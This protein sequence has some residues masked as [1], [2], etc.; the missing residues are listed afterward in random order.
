MYHDIVT[1][2]K[3]VIRHKILETVPGEEDVLNKCQLAAKWWLIQ[4]Q[5][6]ALTPLLPNLPLPSLVLPWDCPP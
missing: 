2:V 3:A 5:S 6:L 4:S 1:R